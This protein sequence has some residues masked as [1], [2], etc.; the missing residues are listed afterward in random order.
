MTFT[1]TS[2]IKPRH[3]LEK[4]MLESNCLKPIC[5]ME[6]MVEQGATNCQV[7]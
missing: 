2:D 4:K 5:G 1:F 6:G 7:G 3:I